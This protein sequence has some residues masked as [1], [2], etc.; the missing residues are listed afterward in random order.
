MMPFDR[1]ATDDAEFE[2][3]LLASARGD[4]GPP[5]VA[6][7]WARLAGAL[8]PI[9]SDPALGGGR[10]AASGGAAPVLGSSTGA[11]VGVG[12]A[13]RW[14][15]LGAVVGSGATAVIFVRAGREAGPGRVD[16]PRAAVPT[17]TVTVAKGAD[18][19]PEPAGGGDGPRGRGAVVAPGR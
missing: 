1:E 15:L 12:V 2:R 7:A 16:P 14:A 13:I 9:A 6:G 4:A 8:A 17:P 10:T 18:P 19:R 5:D 11:R 3:R